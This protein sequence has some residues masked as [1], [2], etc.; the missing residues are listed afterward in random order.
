MVK[1]GG[2]EGTKPTHKMNASHIVKLASLFTAC[3]LI[4][5]YLCYQWGAFRERMKQ[6]KGQKFVRRI[7]GKYKQAR[8]AI[9]FTLN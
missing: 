5:G 8:P 1:L 4:G 6:R 7:R 3:F 9:T 2:Q